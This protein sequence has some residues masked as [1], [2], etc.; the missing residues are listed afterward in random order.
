MALTLHNATVGTYQQILASVSGFMDKGLAHCHESNIDP[1]EIVETRLYPDMAPFRFQIVS[2]V[3]HSRGA[4][5]ATKSGEFRPRSSA[6]EDFATLQQMV[7]DARTAVNEVTPDE[8]NARAS[9][10]LTFKVGDKTIPFTTEDFLLSFSLPNFQ[11]H[12]TTAYDILR[13]KGVKIGKRDYLGQL[14]IKR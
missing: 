13:S 2:V 14:R 1:N 12:A 11:F 3:H 9:N 6:S 4:L 8:L 10:D 7:A 5:E